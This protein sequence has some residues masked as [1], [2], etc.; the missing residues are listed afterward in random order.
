MSQSSFGTQMLH[1]NRREARLKDAAQK[2]LLQERARL[3]KM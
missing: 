3:N 1:Q 2:R